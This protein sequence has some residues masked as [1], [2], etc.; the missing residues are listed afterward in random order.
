MNQMEYHSYERYFNMSLKIAAYMYL[1]RIIKTHAAT[2]KR[3]I[4]AIRSIK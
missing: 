3:Y 1:G 2:R 4:E